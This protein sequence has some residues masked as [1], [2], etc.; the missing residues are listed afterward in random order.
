M[1]EWMV[2]AS[3][4]IVIVFLVHKFLQQRLPKI[5]LY[6]MWLVVLCRLLIPFAVPMPMN[7]NATQPLAT[8]VTQQVQQATDTFAPQIQRGKALVTPQV[9]P[10]DQS[11]S[12]GDGVSSS[13]TTSVVEKMGSVQWFIW[14]WIT[15]AVATL[16]VQIGGYLRYNRLMMRTNEAASAHQQQLFETIMGNPKRTKLFV[17][18][19]VSSPQL[20][21]AWAPRLIL[22]KD[23]YTDEQLTYIFMHEQVHV[24]RLDIVWKWGML[25]ATA[26]HWFNPLVYVMRSAF[27]QSCE[28]ACD[29]AVIRQLNAEQK[30]GY[31]KLLLSLAVQRNQPPANLY[32]TISESKRNLKERLVAI[33]QFRRRSWFIIVL[34]IVLLGVITTG[35]IFVGSRYSDNGGTDNPIQR[36]SVQQGG[37]TFNLER[38]KELTDV[39]DILKNIK[40]QSG[41]LDIRPPDG[42]LNVYYKPSS[43]QPKSYQLWMERNAN[44]S[45][46]YQLWM[47]GD[48]N[49]FIVDEPSHTFATL[50][51]KDSNRL[52]AI[53]ERLQSS[54]E[55]AP[56]SYPHTAITDLTEQQQEVNRFAEYVQIQLHKG[57][58]YKQF[59][60][61]LGEPFKIVTSANSYDKYKYTLVFDPTYLAMSNQRGEDP[62]FAAYKARQIGAE[63]IIT[64]DISSQTIRDYELYYVNPTDEP[65]QYLIRP[66]PERQQRFIELNDGLSTDLQD[67]VTKATANQRILLPNGKYGITWHEINA[68]IS[69][70]TGGTDEPLLNAIGNH[71]EVIS[72]E[73]VMA[74]DEPAILVLVDRTNS[75]A[76]AEQTGKVTN[77]YEY[78][79]IQK[80]IRPYPGRAV[81]PYPGLG[82]IYTLV[83]HVEKPSEAARQ[84]MIQL[85]KGWQTTDLE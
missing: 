22:P 5:I 76:D 7:G 45:I 57:M 41:M 15:G 82:L 13:G 74:G 60:K 14:L 59:T 55:V 63:V 81:G 28:L 33:M 3:I 19:F 4:L 69:I 68:Q 1:S 64:L 62:D 20:L 37:N 49:V 43:S 48:E 30:Q 58:T 40:W 11:A 46:P 27:H 53:I 2:S 10:V 32:A 29:E 65:L 6:G 26:I 35:A 50:K 38:T 34:S 36:I 16:A 23:T 66:D 44:K 12:G 78:W 67:Y 85:V 39:T 73:D 9:E 83:A 75:A 56:Y 25:L 24:R 61:L 47:E 54:T 21:G 79:C 18:A 31:G 42:L 52:K 71:A 77:N 17:N 51:T 8:V 80:K 72:Q 70:T 84:H